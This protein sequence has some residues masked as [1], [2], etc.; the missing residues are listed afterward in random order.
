MSEDLQIIDWEEAAARRLLDAASYEE[1]RQIY[2]EIYDEDNAFWLASHGREGISGSCAKNRALLQ[3]SCSGQGPVLDIGGGTGIAG[4]SLPPDRHYIV[5]DASR[6]VLS[7]GK[8]ESQSRIR[9]MAWATELPFADGSIE[10]VIA[11]DV[12]EHLHEDDIQ[13]CLKECRRVLRPR[14]TLL[15]ATPHR[16]SGP[17]D[18]RG[19]HPEHR[20][21]AGLHLNE[22][23]VYRLLSDMKR[24]GF[25]PQ[26]FVVREY[27]GR[28]WRVPPL[29]FWAGLLEIVVRLVPRRFRRR[30]CTLAVVLAVKS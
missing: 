7:Q 13:R 25:Q 23:T 28:M 17:W 20:R 24:H 30:L 9:V 6:F 26:A 12:L 19:N 5:C 1:R 27:R 10:V 15:V 29:S 2:S 18:A 16:L 8:D 3:D 4:E 11:L 21:R 22:M 14:G